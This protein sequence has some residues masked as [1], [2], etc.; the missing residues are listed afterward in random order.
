M[1]TSNGKT[2]QLLPVPLRRKGINETLA[3][4]C[5]ENDI[6]ELAI[7]GSFA[8]NRSTSQSDVDILVTFRK[9]TAKTLFDLVTLENE[10]KKVLRRKIDLVTP[11]GLSPLL[12]DEILSHR[13]VIYAER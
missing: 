5:R 8:K 10:L 13:R 1:R 4:I 6:I 2:R 9:G 3:K 11:E 7:F 12:K